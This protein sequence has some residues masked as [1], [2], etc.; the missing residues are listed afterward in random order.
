MADGPY[1]N[2]FRKAHQKSIAKRREPHLIEYQAATRCS[3]CKMAFPSDSQPS[4]NE[5]FAHHVSKAHKR[6]Q[7]MEDFSQAAVRI[8][9]E[10]TEDK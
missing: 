2:P 7:T 4:V 6:G 10:A 5:A 3:V 8:V 9:R 1:I